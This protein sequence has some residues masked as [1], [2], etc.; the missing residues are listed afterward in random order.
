[1]NEPEPSIKCDQNSWH[2]RL[3]HETWKNEHF[4][5]V[6]RNF[7]PYMRKL[8]ASMFLFPLILVWRKM[9]ESVQYHEDL[10]KTLFVYGLIVHVFY[11]L[12]YLFSGGVYYEREFEDGVMVSEIVHQMEWWWGTAFYLL[13]IGAV[14][15]VIGLFII[16]A[17]WNDRRK[18]RLREQ[19]KYKKN[20]TVNIFKQYIHAKHSKICP[21]ME[22]YKS[23]NEDEKNNDE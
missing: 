6:P 16:I 11:G 12:M 1:M 10:V 7:C 19:G 3:I 13:S 22:F 23:G 9:P 4:T 21:R 8:I 15:G 2:Y 17:D 18:E 20:Q 14:G 5:P